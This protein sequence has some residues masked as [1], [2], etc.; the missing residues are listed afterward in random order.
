MK[1]IHV[2]GTTRCRFRTVFCLG[3]KLYSPTGPLSVY[4]PLSCEFYQQD[5]GSKCSWTFWGVR[6]RWRFPGPQLPLRRI[7][8]L[9]VYRCWERRIGSCCESSLRLRHIIEPLGAVS[10]GQKSSWRGMLPCL[11]V[12]RLL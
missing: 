10:R 8:W 5:R 4:A 9:I 7:V 1:H 3:Q 11:Q 12:R 2:A 6:R